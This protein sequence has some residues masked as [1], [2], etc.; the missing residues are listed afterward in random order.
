MG[1]IAPIFVAPC[2][3]SLGNGNSKSAYSVEVSSRTTR[4]RGLHVIH[5]EP[6]LRRGE[7]SILPVLFLRQ[8]H[9]KPLQPLTK[10][11]EAV[12]HVTTDERPERVRSLK[13]SGMES[14]PGVVPQESGLVSL[15]HTL[16][17]LE[18][19]LNRVIR[20]S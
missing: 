19:I 14:E 15:Q 6:L 7:D 13:R 17:L 9:K 5:L 18:I 20:P 11:R 3:Y 10:E 4:G 16:S 12:L 1:K 8:T 2:R